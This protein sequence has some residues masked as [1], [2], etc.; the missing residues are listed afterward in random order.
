MNSFQ[1]DL[2]DTDLCRNPPEALEDLA[3]C[4]NS[5][6]KDILDKHAPLITRSIKERPRVPWFN[7]EIKM[8]KRERRKAEKKWRR[9]K[10]YTD[11]A[12]FKIKR[13]ATTALMNKARREFYTNFIEENSKDQKKLFAASNRLL[14][15][16][17]ADCLPPTI[18]KAQF[19]ED[20]GKFF[21]QKIVNIRSRLDSQ[22]DAD[23][24]KHDTEDIESSFVHLTEFQMLTEQ[25]VKS[26]IRYSSLKSCV[27]DPMPSTLVSQCDV[28]LPVLT[29]L[30][31]TS[32]KSGQFPAVWK[33]ALVLPLLKKPGL[34]ILFKNFRP[35]SNLPFVSKLTESAVYNQTHGHICKNNLYPPNQ[36][37]YRKNYSTETALLKVKNDI[38]LNMNKQHVTLLILLD[39]SAAFDTVDHNVLLRRLHSKFGISGTALEWFSSYLRGRS[40]RVMVQGNLS[41]KLNLEFGVPQG[42]CLGPL[43]FTIYASKLFDVI[44]EHLPTVHC[45]ADDTQLYVSFSPNKSTGQSEAVNAIQHCVKDVRN[46]M[47]NDKLLLNDDK[48]EFLMIG[49]KQ[50]LAKVN[51]DH[52]LIG[53]SAIRPKGVVKNLGTWLDSTLSMNS[54][55]NNICSN[56]FY[57][58]YNIRRIRKYLSRRSTETLI[59]AFVSSRVDY[60]NSLLYGLPTYQLHKLQRVQNAAAR[61][62]FQESKYCH[63]SPLLFNLHWLPVKFRIDFKILLLTYKAINGL[64]PFYLKELINLKVPCKYKLRSDCDGLLLNTVKFKTLKTLGDRSFAVAAPQLWNSLPYAIRSSPS[65][66][67]FKQTLKTFLFQKAFL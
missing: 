59:H 30:I 49:T 56:A 16:G 64:A 34:D 23:Y 19:A 27:L 46:W 35:V 52:I 61:L 6:L 54:H 28:L 37:S 39:L 8:A 17:S 50:Q 43:L 20:I 10:L 60:C 5:T 14:N 63:V 67:S 25:D 58:L 1:S 9:T 33:E 12:A 7:E 18:D 42:S 29:R 38:L 66:A 44:K 62:I 32:L 22:G 2:A 48:T 36:S 13:N 57:Y 41:Q 4:Y 26:L 31:N 21:I 45:Y 11:L 3:K 65:V 24:H 51:I 40:Q 53:D 15:R 55:V 47:N